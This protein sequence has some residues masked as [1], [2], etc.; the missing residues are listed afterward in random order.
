[1]NNNWQPRIG[2]KVVA[3]KTSQERFGVKIIKGKTYTCNDTRVCPKCGLVSIS[4]EEL[5]YPTHAVF[6]TQCCNGKIPQFYAKH[7]RGLSKYFAP[8]NEYPDATAS[9]AA[10]FTDIE[11]YDGEPVSVPRE[12]IS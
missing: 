5:I 12:V 1:M 7:A 9:I 2:Q 3:L 4:L 11:R 10:E 6:N 8:L